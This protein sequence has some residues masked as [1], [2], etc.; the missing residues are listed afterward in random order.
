[1]MLNSRKTCAI[2]GVLDVLSFDVNEVLLETDLGMLMIRGKDLHINRLTLE[3][4]EVD[5]EG[6]I[7]SLTYSETTGYGEKAEGL[8]S[9]LFR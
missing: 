6:T 8:F 7:D 9:K 3:K 2:T 4:G 5:V 1:M